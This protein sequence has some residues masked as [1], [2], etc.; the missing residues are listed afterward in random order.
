MFVSGREMDLSYVAADWPIREIVIGD[1]A[2]W[3]L[4]YKKVKKLFHLVRLSI[5]SSKATF[6]TPMSSA[7]AK[8]SLSSSGTICLCSSMS[9]ATIGSG[10]YRKGW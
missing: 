6:K 2:T 3:K 10:L 7:L 1:A 4:K 5:A 8:L 9:W